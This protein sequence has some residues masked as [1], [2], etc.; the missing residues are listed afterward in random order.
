M[1]I[2]PFSSEYSSEAKSFVLGVLS[3]EGFQYDPMKDSD[4]DF[5]QDNYPGKGGA[6]YICLFN[7]EVVGTSAVR[8]L[9]SGICE[10][11]RLYVRKD[12]RGKGIGM[13]L[14][15]KALAY[16]ENNYSCARLKTDSSL[17]KAVSIYVRNGFS[18]VKEE[19]R[20]IYFEK[21][22]LRT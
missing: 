4:L 19:E 3:E 17:K 11:K 21:S 6:F 2:V 8:N 14:F 16:A 13:A 18:V 20:T 10:I 12:W 15:R 1:N 7:D 5:I 9:G 22:L